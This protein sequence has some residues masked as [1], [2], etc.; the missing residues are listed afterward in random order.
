MIEGSF[1][2]ERESDSKQC[3]GLSALNELEQILSLDSVLI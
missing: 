2:V 3:L 1:P